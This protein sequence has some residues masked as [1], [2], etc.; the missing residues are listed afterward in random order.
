MGGQRMNLCKAASVAIAFAVLLA[1][2][3]PAHAAGVDYKGW[4]GNLDIALTQPNSLDQNYANHV[5]FPGNGAVE[6]ERLEMDND[7]SATFKL[8]VGFSWGKKGRLQVSYWQ[9]D[10]DDE[11]DDILNGGVYPSI[12]GYGVYGGQYIYNPAGVEFEA[13][14][15]TKATAL[16]LD[17]I[18]PMTAGETL[19]IHWLAGLRVASFE[20]D[21]AF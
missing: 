15:D 11:N 5:Q 8:D 18:R 17:Y 9:F 1:L 16:D 7:D 2:G 4:Y 3:T 13:T 21:M 19:T 10:N 12:F 20:E 6:T 14:A